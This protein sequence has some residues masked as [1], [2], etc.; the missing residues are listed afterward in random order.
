M[1]LRFQPARGA[2]V[3]LTSS[4]RGPAGAAATATV[5]TTTTGA[6]GTS[7]AVANA[8]STS[9]AVFNFTIPRGAVPAIGFNFDTTTTDADPGAG[10]VR[11]NNATPASVTAI[12]FD[13]A[14]RDGNTVTTWLDSFDDSTT[15]AKGTLTFTPAA[16]PSAK[17]IY[18][19]SGSVVDGTGYRKVTVT[20]VAGT[21]LPTAAAHLAVAF[22]R[23]GDKGADGSGTFPGS[24]TDNAVVRFDGAAGTTVQ[25]SGVII[26]DSNN[27]S[28]VVALAATTIEL[29]HASDTTLSRVSAGV[30]A[31]EGSNVLLASGLGSVTQAFDADL[32]TLAALGN[33]KVVYSDGSSVVTALSLGADATVFAANGVSSAPTFRSLDNLGGLIKAGNQT[34]TGGFSATSFNAGTKSSGT[35][36]PAASDGNVQHATNGGAH[37][38]APPS[39]VCSIL[40][41]Y[42]NNG[43]AGAITTSGFTKVVG[44]FTTTDTNKFH[45]WITKGNAYS[46]LIIQALQ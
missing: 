12:Y 24:S 33:W 21:T 39:T 5:G 45:C 28:G 46:S 8:G 1:P 27:V 32:A 18:A 34:T 13:N 10:D 2:A 15:T 16:T 4:S 9:A 37:T 30:V 43:S 38:L 35:Y 19:V 40:V 36:T 42:L 14:D 23:T 17:L 26:D 22:S 7:A 25:N 31:V 44:S 29:G 3:V 11:F 6:E 41:E 20:H